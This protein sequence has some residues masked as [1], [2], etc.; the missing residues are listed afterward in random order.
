MT[1]GMSHDVTEGQSPDLRYKVGTQQVLALYYFCLQCHRCP[2]L[3]SGAQRSL[4]VMRASRISSDLCQKPSVEVRQERLPVASVCI[5]SSQCLQ[6][7][8][9]AENTVNT[10]H[11]GIYSPSW[12][13]WCLEL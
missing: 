7:A 8:A 13:S 1:L 10:T 6:S 9:K 3:V 11:P 4:W 2:N 12:E 5:L